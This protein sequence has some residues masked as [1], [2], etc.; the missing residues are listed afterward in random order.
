MGPVTGFA[1]ASQDL[2][3]TLVSHR[4]ES[5]AATKRNDSRLLGRLP[6][7]APM[8]G[9]TPHRLQARTQLAGRPLA[10]RHNGAAL[11]AENELAEM[12]AFL[13]EHGRR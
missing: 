3:V 13:A 8:L 7:P 10:A 5:N 2:R 4:W 9:A 11:L 12:C 1:G 6:S